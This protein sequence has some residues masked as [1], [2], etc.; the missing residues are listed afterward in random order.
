[1]TV[2]LKKLTWQQ[3]KNF[4]A[5]YV[6]SS[7]NCNLS[8]FRYYTINSHVLIGTNP[9]INKAIHVLSIHGFAV[10]SISIPGPSQNLISPSVTC[11][12]ANVIL[13]CQNDV[14]NSPGSCIFKMFTGDMAFR[15]IIGTGKKELK[16]HFLHGFRMTKWFYAIIAIKQDFL[17]HLHL[18]SLSWNVENLAIVFMQ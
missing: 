3:L 5:W 1:M 15:A 16:K 18:L 11:T 12:V 2:P 8:K 13:W 9:C 17:I 4:E 14:F 6:F 7:E 10:L